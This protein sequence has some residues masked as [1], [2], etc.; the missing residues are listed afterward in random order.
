MWCD[1]CRA[2]GAIHCAHPDECGNMRSNMAA[3]D[4]WNAWLDDLPIDAQFQPAIDRLQDFISGLA[5]L[6]PAASPAPPDA[7]AAGMR[8]AADILWN[9]AN[10]FS[11]DRYQTLNAAHDW[12]VQ[13][14]PAASPAPWSPPPEADRPD[15][16][17]C[18]ARNINGTWKHVCWQSGRW[19]IRGDQ[20]MAVN[21]PTA[22]APLPSA[23][24]GEAT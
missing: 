10:D 22:F 19:T 7:Y 11:D 1:A 21:H 5:A 24:K 6:A 23:Q 13:S 3:A 16:F 8:N 17:E 20:T 2:V 4:N 14:I 12:L 15:G 9:Y 18:L